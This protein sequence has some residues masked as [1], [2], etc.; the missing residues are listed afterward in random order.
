MISLQANGRRY[1]FI[2]TRVCTR[3]GRKQVRR[4]SHGD[5]TPYTDAF[6]FEEFFS[7]SSNTTRQDDPIR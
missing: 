5:S 7:H 3:C 4:N 6:R 1:P 2:A